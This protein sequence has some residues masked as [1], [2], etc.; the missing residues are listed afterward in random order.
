MNLYLRFL[1]YARPYWHLALAASICF[2]A[3][4]F[5]GAYPIQLFKRAVDVA[6][7]DA[8]GEADVFFWL[9]L[10]YIL[11]RVA[12]GGVQLAES[13]LSKRLVQNVV[14][15]LQGDLY[16]HLQ[17]LSIGFYETQGSGDI[18]SRA[19][20]DVGAVAGGFM[21]PL[22]RLAGELTQLAWALYFLVR[23]DPRLTAISLA[24]APPLGY[25]VYRFGDRMRVLAG[26]YRIAQSRLWSFLA[27][28]IAGMREIQIFTREERELERFRAHAQEINQL[29]LQ[30]SLL[31]ATLTFCSG[32]LF[33]AGE[34]VILL[35]GGLSVYGGTM[36]PGNLTAF[37]MY[38][39]MLYNPVITISRRYDQ[40]QRTLAS[41]VRVFQVLDRVPEVRDRPGAVPLSPI[42]GEVRFEHVSFAYHEDREV[43]HDISLRAAPG[44]TIALVGHSGG[45][46]TT[47]SKL[48]PRFYDPDRGKVFVDG[49]DLRDVTLRSLRQQ[50]AVVFQDSFL[51]NGTVRD[52]IAYGKPEALEAEIVAAAKAANVHPFVSELPDGYET[53][54]G[55]RG[56]RLSGGQRQRVTIARALLQDP[57]ILILD[58]ATSAV[59]SET[60]R[61]IQEALNRLMHARP[62]TSRPETSG[63]GTSRP[64][65][66][67]VIAHRLSTIQ[68]ADQILVVEGGQIVEQGRH[69]DLLAL[70]GVYSR[71]YA[72]QF[73]REE[74]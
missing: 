15:D 19:L 57:G 69:A 11:L 22:T 35:L 14:Y 13:Y 47:I 63:M 59:D 52:N 27:E 37:L 42:A 65:T 18:M 16:A 34:T 8:P 5:L 10:Q 67:L 39:R 72:E 7:G 2:V 29:G 6:V 49:Q 24:V 46:K 38:L 60:E 66:S 53:V 71:L 44:E 20:G 9:A 32:L 23:I 48:I 25:A 40:I 62:E 30:D 51:F 74:T 50:V 73:R 28:N 56:I 64:R 61:L 68:H 12:L 36:S 33:S 41:A 55:E 54:I 58:E 17:S 31:N 21:G 4:G 26:R 45:G 43:L 70:G 1:R 3:S